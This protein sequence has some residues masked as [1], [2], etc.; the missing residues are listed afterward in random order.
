M[1]MRRHGVEPGM[2]RLPTTNGDSPRRLRLA[3]L[4]RRLPNDRATIAETARACLGIRDAWV[5]TI[6]TTVVGETAF[7]GGRIQRLRS[8]SWP[9]VVGTALLYLPAEPVEWPAL[10]ILA[11]GHGAGNVARLSVWP[12][13]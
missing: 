3:V 11:C 13:M 5:P 4:N 6:H 2:R 12:G 7:D 1:A 10:V 8:T 9:G